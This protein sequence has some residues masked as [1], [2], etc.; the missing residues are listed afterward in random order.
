MDCLAKKQET[1][2]CLIGKC[3]LNFKGKPSRNA[4]KPVLTSS[5]ELDQFPNDIFFVDVQ[6]QTK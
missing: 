1:K 3:F 5:I 6:S 2:R 4:C